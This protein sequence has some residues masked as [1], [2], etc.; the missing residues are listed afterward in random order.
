MGKAILKF[1]NIDIEKNKFY[2]NFYYFL[3]D[4][5]IEKILISIF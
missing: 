5:D 4:V 3:N 1:G 2:F